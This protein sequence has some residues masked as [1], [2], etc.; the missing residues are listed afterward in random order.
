MTLPGQG[1]CALLCHVHTMRHHIPM[2]LS[3]V[4][5]AAMPLLVQADIET[6][7]VRTFKT[8]DLKKKNPFLRKSSMQQVECVVWILRTFSTQSR[9]DPYYTPQQF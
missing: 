2:A 6:S 4:F 1:L 9:R 8:R 3:A 5:T 7:K